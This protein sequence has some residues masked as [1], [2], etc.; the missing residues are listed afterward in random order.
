MS[1]EIAEAALLELMDEARTLVQSDRN[2]VAAY[3]EAMGGWPE[4]VTTDRNKGG[5]TFV[6]SE[7]EGVIGA[8]V[9]DVVAAAPLSHGDTPHRFQKP[10]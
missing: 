4:I 2:S 9:D 7:I 3:V 6:F 10:L 8:T 1:R 5:N